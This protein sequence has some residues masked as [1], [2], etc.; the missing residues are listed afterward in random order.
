ML[1]NKHGVS[2]LAAGVFAFA[3]TGASATTMLQMTFEELVADSSV[4][5]VGEAIDSR[6]VESPS[7][8]RMTIT[9][10]KVNDAVV[11]SAGS[12]VQVATP[13]GVFRSGKFLLRESTADTP[14]FA[15]GSEHML[16]LNP[17][18]SKSLAIVGVNQ[19]ATAVFKGKKGR[20]VILPGGEGVETVAAAAKRVRAARAS[21]ETR[22]KRE[23][24]E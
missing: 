18:P 10:F 5:L 22:I 14:I 8:G 3:A 19:G 15:M 20:S 4:V 23:T 7:E 6:V 9:S 11:G 24:T 2:L 16:F 21:G 13:G 1:K 12:V 17:G